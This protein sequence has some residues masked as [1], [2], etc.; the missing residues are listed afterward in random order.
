MGNLSTYSAR[1][2]ARKNFSSHGGIL[3]KLSEPGGVVSK[4]APVPPWPGPPGH[5]VSKAAR[6]PEAYYIYSRLN[7]PVFQCQSKTNCRASTAVAGRHSWAIKTGTSS[8]EISLHFI[9]CDGH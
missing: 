1:V 6:T 2:S 5:L 9:S 7:L 4:A 3:Q 8:V